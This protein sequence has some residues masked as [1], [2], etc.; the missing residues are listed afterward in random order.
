M[1]ASP[2]QV[3]VLSN[4]DAQHG[5]AVVYLHSLLEPSTLPSCRPSKYDTDVW[6]TLRPYLKSRGYRLITQRDAQLQ[7]AKASK[8]PVP[9]Q[10]NGP[11]KDDDTL[12]SATFVR[13]SF[14][15]FCPIRNFSLERC[16]I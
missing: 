4:A 14:P 15:S 9:D 13:P 1:Q 6:Q 11:P 10:W 16:R 7:M 3:Q 5:I 2:A 12:Y 8:E